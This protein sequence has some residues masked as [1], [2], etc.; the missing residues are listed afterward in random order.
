M[1]R[2]APSHLALIGMLVCACGGGGSPQ[3]HVAAVTIAPT[4]ATVPPSGTRSFTATVTQVDDPRITWSVL[5]GDAG[6]TVSEAG[7]YTA[8]ATRGMYH[9]V[10][11][12]AADDSA[13]AAALINVSSYD[14]LPAERL[15]QWNPGLDSAGG[16]PNRTQIYVTLKASDYGNGT[17]DAAAAIQAKLDSCPENEV[18]LLSAGTFFVDSTITVPS[19]V[20]LRGAGPGDGKGSGGTLI[21]RSLTAPAVPTSTFKRALQIGD[22]G[23]TPV[24]TRLTADGWKE[25]RTIA[26]ASASGFQVGDLV[27][28]DELDDP[29]LVDCGDNACPYYFSRKGRANSQVN[30]IAAIS[31]NT[32]TLSAP[33]HIAFRVARSAEVT[34]RGAGTTNAGIESLRVQYGTDDNLTLNGA[35]YSWIKNVE[36][37]R[38]QGDSVGIDGSFRCVVRE[39]FFHDTDNPTPGGGG[40]GISFSWGSADNL[41]EN[42][43]SV[44]FN[45]VMVMR[46]SG[47]GNVVAYNYLDDGYI[48]YNLGWVEVGLN[49][50]HETLPHYEL[51][52]GNQAFNID[53]DSTWGNSIYVTFFRN[54]ATGLRRNSTGTASNS[55]KLQDT[56][57]RRMVGLMHGHW[58]QSFVGNVLGYKE[59]TPDPGYTSFVYET[60]EGCPVWEL[61][62]NPTNWKAV[63][64]PKVLSTIIRDGNYDYF[65]NQAHWQNPATGIPDSLYL[66]GKPSFFGS[67]AWPWVDG[68]NATTPLPGSLPARVRYD[69]GKPNG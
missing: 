69:A 46:S 45:K 27:S 17:K 25:S 13:A 36:S 63:P 24:T 49:S 1:N 21:T 57:N 20:V 39:S 10:A 37:L 53:N 41:V 65:T 32:F 2:L 56:S 12:S 68:S 35:K 19:N 47:G 22:G 23:G 60:G 28:I 7:E 18:V 50:S 3:A 9:V 61:G 64:D 51:F 52:E 29:E 58:W 66:T 67:S 43:I 42:N 4:A 31:G 59:M 26:V 16:I 54:Q 34:G 14:I 6:G 48:S 15:T 5:E 8:P 44:R 62:Y 55:G 33:L 11:K 40:Y 30:E 38:S